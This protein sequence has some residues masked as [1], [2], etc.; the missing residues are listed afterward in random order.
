MPDSNAADGACP[1][2][3]QGAADADAE[4]LPCLDRPGSN[5]LVVRSAGK[6]LVDPEARDTV[7]AGPAT[8]GEGQ[9]AVVAKNYRLAGRRDH[10]SGGARRKGLLN[11]VDGHRHGS[12]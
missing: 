6:G 8:G 3:A 7:R 12:E 11:G 2:L 5:D 1:D 10:G 4:Q 9:A